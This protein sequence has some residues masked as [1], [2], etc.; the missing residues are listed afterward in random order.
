MEIDYSETVKYLGFHQIAQISK[1]V[2]F[3]LSKIRHC[4]KSVNSEL[5]LKLVKGVICPIVD[6]AAIIYH[7]FGIHGTNEDENKLQIL[8]N[9]CIR[10]VCNLTNRDHVSNYYSELELLNAH[11]RRTFLISCIIYSFLQ[12]GQPANLANIF[13]VNKNNTR[14]GK[15]TISL[16]TKQIKKTR[17]EFLLEHC[18]CKLWN[19]IPI[20]IRNLPTKNQF[21]NQYKKYLQNKQNTN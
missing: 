1:N 13:N 8:M 7:G 2:N 21:A 11:N 15:D 16:V 3:A 14:S 12:T 18:A 17:D 19:S 20:D 9:S 4:R 10:Y 6:Y 5:K